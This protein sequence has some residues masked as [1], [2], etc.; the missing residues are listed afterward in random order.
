MKQNLLL[1]LSLITLVLT[2]VFFNNNFVTASE[3]RTVD[4]FYSPSC[5]HCQ[6][7]IPLI[8]VLSNGEYSSI[9]KWNFFDV[10]NG[11][12]DIDGVP[13]LIFDNKVKLQGSYE[14]PKYAKCYLEEQTTKECP[15]YSAD[16]CTNDWF[17]RE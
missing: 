12:Y 4:F 14:I 7:V 1:V 11:S 13:T 8:N 15:T 17:I 3:V 2:L 16:F 10:T 5:Q 6:Q 9:W